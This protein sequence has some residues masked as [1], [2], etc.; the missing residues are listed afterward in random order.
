[1]ATETTFDIVIAGGGTAG[2]ALASRLKQGN[3]SLSIA[4]IER[5][6]DDHTNELVMN[7]WGRTRLEGAGLDTPYPT[8]PQ[9]HMD[10]RVIKLHAGNVL[11]GSSAAN[12]GFWM[13]PDR[14]DLD[15]W[16]G[17][18]DGEEGS[19]RWTY[20]GLLPHLKRI[21]SHWDRE[22]SDREAHGFDG[23]FKTRTSPEL[24]LRQPIHDGLVS[25][26]FEDNPDNLNGTPFGI[27]RHC[28]NWTP[29][30]QPAAAV[31][32]LSGV[33]VITNATIHKIL[34]EK[35]YGQDVRAT[36][37]QLVDGRK[38]LASKEVVLSC[39]AYRTPQ[40]LL[41]SGIGPA[42]DLFRHGIETIVDS[43]HVGKTFFDHSGIFIPWKLDSAAAEAGLAMG[44]PKYMAN[45]SFKGATP[46]D[47]MTIG[48]LDPSALQKQL[49]KDSPTASISPTH[50]LL[51]HRA[52]YWLATTY[53]ASGSIS[54]EGMQ[55]IPF[56]GN[57]ITFS[58]LNFLPTSRGTITLSSSNPLDYPVCDPNYFA[59]EH[60]RFVLREGIRQILRLAQSEPLQP[61]LSPTDQLA[62]TNF[63]PLSLSTTDADLDARVRRSAITIHHGMGSASMGKVVD[64]KLRVKGVRG[65]RVCDASVFPGPLS[66]TP[67]AVVYA[68]AESCA[69]MMVGELA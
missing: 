49:Q 54:G 56:D 30:R 61:Y 6:S 39:G 15:L 62:P 64:A 34:L 47:W 37:V 35:K 13:R 4:L 12:A 41:L 63:P 65:L 3:K 7:A 50:P 68:V 24:P 48:A 58:T 32:D 51:A 52:H 17:H 9:K 31:Y 60:D 36:G 18:L 21:E 23:P 29:L 28:D 67:Q 25:L 43:P 57:Y 33:S 19:E 11:S 66:A 1:M 59:T 69:E 8:V 20:Q 22:G 16:A 40:I 26:G 46:I 14:K 55:E 45:P 42:E 5:G 44:H 53:Y 2:C 27:G 38:F 10:D